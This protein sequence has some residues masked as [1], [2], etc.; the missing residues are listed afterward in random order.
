MSSPGDRKIE[1]GAGGGTRTHT[2]RLTKAALHRLKLR[3][4]A[5]V[6][7]LTHEPFPF[8]ILLDNPSLSKSG[9]LLYSPRISEYYP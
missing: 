6:V 7:I 4:L 3:L 5:S 2:L 1:N 9:L 8:K